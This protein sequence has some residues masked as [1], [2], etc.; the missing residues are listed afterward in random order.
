MGLKT[1]RHGGF[2]QLV[3][4]R[5]FPMQSSLCLS[6]PRNLHCSLPAPPE[7]CYSLVIT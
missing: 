6:P 4:V 2:S 1:Q 3:A 5:C 7:I